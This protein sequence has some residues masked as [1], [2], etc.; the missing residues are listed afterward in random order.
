MCVCIYVYIFFNIFIY[1]FV[2]IYVWM[3]VYAFVYLSACFLD[4]KVIHI[5][6]TCMPIVTFCYLIIIYKKINRIYIYI[7][8]IYLHINDNPI[9]YFVQCKHSL[10]FR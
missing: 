1:A 8:M 4:T 9:T 6:H 2:C 5:E 7:Y 3:Y 10:T